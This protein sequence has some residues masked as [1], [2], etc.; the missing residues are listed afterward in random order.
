[1]A[2]AA[3]VGFR[4]DTEKT[5]R[6]ATK[7]SNIAEGFYRSMGR[8]IDIIHLNGSI[9]I[10]PILGLLGT[11]IG[12]IKTLMA[13]NAQAVVSRVELFNGSMEAL[14]SAALGLVVAIPVIV[15]YGSL[16][17][18]LDRAVVDLEAA[19]SQIIGYLSNKREEQKEARR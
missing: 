15:M 12:F 19:A 5:L 17:V 9:E 2:V 7:F 11:I 6:V 3:P 16:R 14:V 4:D 10:A 1:M 13:A 8:D 18:R